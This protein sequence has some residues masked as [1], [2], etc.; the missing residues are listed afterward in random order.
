MFF[1][2]IIMT[3][4]IFI[5]FVFYGFFFFSFRQ[6]FLK[7]KTYVSIFFKNSFFFRKK[8]FFYDLSF[9]SKLFFNHNY[10]MWTSSVVY[11][12]GRKFFLKKIFLFNFGRKIYKYLVKKDFLSPFGFAKFISKVFEISW[13]RFYKRN[14]SLFNVDSS[15]GKVNSN[16][17][18]YLDKNV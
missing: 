9:L 14:F 16:V 12:F 6:L 17:S 10:N 4:G 8:S 5:M 3:L 18:F 1:F 13:G 11:S 15:F 7:F 2:C